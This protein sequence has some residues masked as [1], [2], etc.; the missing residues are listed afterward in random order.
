VTE[1]WTT[2]QRHAL[3]LVRKRLFEFFPREVVRDV[4]DEPA[5]FQIEGLG[6]LWVIPSSNADRPSIIG[7]SSAHLGPEAPKAPDREIGPGE[8]PTWTFSSADPWAVTRAIEHAAAF[9][10]RAARS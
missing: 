10:R 8:S 6:H 5:S 9:L 3:S 1:E 7:A 4:A 2:E